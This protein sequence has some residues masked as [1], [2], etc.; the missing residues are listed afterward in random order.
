M[1]SIFEREGVDFQSVTYIFC[2]DYF[3]LDLNRSFL[4]HNNFTDILT[5]TLSEKN[6]PIISEIYISIER[7]KEN[8]IRFKTLYLTE[9][10]R[11]LIHGILHLCGYLDKSKQ[12]KIKMR[13]LE[14]Q[15]ISEF[16]FT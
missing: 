8:A 15:Y 3:V 5:F 2:K 9:L 11:V 10:L 7:V 12:Q 4:S 13:K 16:S 6:S 1:V 14:D